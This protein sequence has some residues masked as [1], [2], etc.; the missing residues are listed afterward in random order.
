MEHAFFA[1]EALPPIDYDLQSGE[2][3]PSGIFARVNTMCNVAVR[4]CGSKKIDIVSTICVVL[5][6]NIQY[7]GKSGH[8]GIRGV[9]PKLLNESFPG[10]L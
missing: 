3:L 4:R 10:V 2:Y 7:Q 8:V 6:I 1:V 9:G 5:T